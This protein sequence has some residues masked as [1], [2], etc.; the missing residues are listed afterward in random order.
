[1]CVLRIENRMKIFDVKLF[2]VMHAEKTIVK[3]TIINYVCVYKNFQIKFICVNCE[4]GFKTV[5]LEIVT[6]RLRRKK[7]VISGGREREDNNFI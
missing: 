7:N 4:C 6:L 5:C 3:C 1:M 2:L